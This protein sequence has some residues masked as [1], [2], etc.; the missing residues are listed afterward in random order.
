M[1]PQWPSRPRVSGPCWNFGVYDHACRLTVQWH[2][3]DCILCCSLWQVP[4]FM[5]VRKCLRMLVLVVCVDIS[6]SNVLTVVSVPWSYENECWN[7][8]NSSIVTQKCRW[9]DCWSG[10]YE[11]SYWNLSQWPCVHDTI[12]DTCE[13]DEFM[14][15]FGSDEPQVED[16]QSRLKHNTEFWK[17]HPLYFTAL[18]KAIAFP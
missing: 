7:T 11:R 16:V 2:K 4:V 1:V 18:R 8:D 6:W 3:E 14:L 9:G 12:V 15:E 13:N 10:S 5:W 17:P